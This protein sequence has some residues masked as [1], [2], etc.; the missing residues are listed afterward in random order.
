MD[1]KTE[2]STTLRPLAPMILN[3]GSTTEYLEFACPIEIVP[4][5]SCKLRVN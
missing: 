5:Y 2:A 1:G 3:A 4:Q